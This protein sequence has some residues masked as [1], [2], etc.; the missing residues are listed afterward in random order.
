MSSINRNKIV[1]RVDANF[2]LGIGHLMR[3]MA[4]IN[5]IHHVYEIYFILRSSSSFF[6]NLIESNGFHAI[7]IET[8]D[9]EIEDTLTIINK[10]DPS[11]IIVDH[12]ELDFI[13]ESNFYE[14]YK[15]IVIDD[16]CNRKHK[17]HYLIDS[18]FLRN[19]ADYI[20]K[21]N[22]ECIVFSGSKYAFINDS[23]LKYR[24]KSI[25]KRVTTKSI[26]NVLISFGGTD[27]LRLSEKAYRIVRSIKNEVNISIVTTS[28]NK[29]L[30][31]LKCILE[32]DSQCSLYVDEMNMPQRFLE[33]DVAIGG[34]GG[35][36][37]ERAVLGLPCLGVVVA[38]NQLEL[39]L[40]LSKFGAI[41]I[42]DIDELENSIKDFLKRDMSLW[43]KQSKHC[44]DVTDG[45]GISRI[46]NNIFDIPP[47]IELHNITESDSDLLYKWQIEPDARRYSRNEKIPSQAEHVVWFK[48]SL[49]NKS[50]RMWKVYFKYQYCGYARL[51]RLSDSE[52]V[53]ILISK[54]FQGLGIGSQVIE[55]LK[56][57][58]LF[59]KL[60]AEVDKR[61]TVSS[62]LFKK[63]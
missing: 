2:E 62:G 53:S 1:I 14:I 20:D 49:I 47:E 39:A 26:F 40:G 15:I 50:R 12:Y 27:N 21:V 29:N 60:D 10:I 3:C 18:I 45:L 51:D 35:S 23:F 9:N 33:N 61:N 6:K 25:S 42:G 38:Q 30:S 5:A 28:A 54:S 36:S 43:Y 11:Y 7:F 19:G 46:C 37:L 13:W 55:K 16:L 34:I 8:N 41:I 52:E 17:C 57:N 59:G 32:K 44:L 48:H 24:L 22:S 63:K 58:S 31:D 4:L 56:E